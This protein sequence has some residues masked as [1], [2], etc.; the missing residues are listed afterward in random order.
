MAYNENRESDIFLGN[1]N[2][3]LSNYVTPAKS[4]YALKP[5]KINN[6]FKDINKLRKNCEFFFFMVTS[7]TPQKIGAT[8]IF[9]SNREF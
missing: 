6:L 8:F 1:Y 3:F 4:N 5:I 9:G 7:I 2:Y